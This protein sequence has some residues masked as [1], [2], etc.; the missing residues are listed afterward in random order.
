MNQDILL[1]INKSIEQSSSIG[2]VLPSYVTVDIYAS[3]LALQNW[4]IGMGKTVFLYGVGKIPQYEFFD[5]PEIPLVNFS[6]NNQLQI[7]I[8]SLNAT[9]SSLRY[10]K[11]ENGL[12]VYINIKDG[13]IKSDDVVVTP[14]ALNPDLLFLLDGADYEAFGDFYKKNVAVITTTKK[15]SLSTNPSHNYFAAINFVNTEV[16]SLSE[17]VYDLIDSKNVG[18]FSERVA[19]N[20]LAGIISQTQSYRSS[21]TNPQTLNKSAKL[22]RAGARQQDIIKD[23]YKTKPYNFLQLWGR[24]LARVVYYTENNFLQTTLTKQDFIKTS[25]TTQVIPQVLIDLIEMSS[26]FNIFA[27][28]VEQDSGVNLYL[29]SLPHVNLQKYFKA[30]DIDS[31]TE[32][33]P[34]FGNYIYTSFLIP[35]LELATVEQTL[36][37]ISF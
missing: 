12:T 31:D 5:N 3:S 11:T 22:I 37:K 33:L 32:L 26:G 8:S 21:K 10:E 13:Q 28:V 17:L 7:S 18:E 4:L 9:P 25:L 14:P 34:L 2:I 36:A 6:D 15:I 29:A 27:L 1:Q 30:F 35:D 23:L 20:L 16:S 24:A 19:T